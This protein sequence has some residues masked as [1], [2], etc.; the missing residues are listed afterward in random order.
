MKM[1]SRYRYM[2][3]A[4][5]AASLRAKDAAAVTADTAGAEL[6]LDVLTGYWTSGE[7]ADKT[8]AVVTNVTAGG[9][10]SNQTAT[11]TLVSA[12]DTDT[13]T[14]DDGVNDPVDFVAGTDFS[15]AGDDTADAAAL[16]EAINDATEAGDLNV[17]ATSALG[18]VTVTNLNGGGMAITE[19]ESTIT[20][21]AITGNNETY[22]LNLTTNNGVVIGKATVTRTGQYVILLDMDTVELSDPTAVS[23][24][25]DV[26]VSG[27]APSIDFFAWIAPV[28]A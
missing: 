7:L 1:H 2:F 9:A 14:I 11:I 20:V 13:V 26:D 18:V 24:S 27:V 16:A 3:D 23:I 12:V 15:V 6:T 28:Q 4:A 5:P 19:S 17:T 10:K 25:L 21:S 22:V 8:L